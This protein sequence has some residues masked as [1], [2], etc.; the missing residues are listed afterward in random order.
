MRELFIFD[1]LTTAIGEHEPR[2]SVVFCPDP[3]ISHS[4]LKTNL[5]HHFE[6][7]LPPDRLLLVGTDACKDRLTQIANAPETKAALQEMT[8]WIN[9]PTIETLLQ[10]REGRFLQDGKE[11]PRAATQRI[12]KEG[13]LHLFQVRGGLLQSG[14]GFHYRKPSTAHCNKFVRTANV[15]VHGAEISFIGFWLLPQLRN[16][17][18]YLYTD[19]AAI[20]ALAYAMVLLKQQLNASYP[21]P[22]ITSFGSYDGIELCYFEHPSLVL[23]SASTSGNLED[24]LVHKKHL[25]RSEITTIYALGKMHAKANVLCNLGEHG[26][27]PV[28]N[29]DA[30]NCP[31]CRRNVPLIGITGEQFLPETPAVRSELL[32]VNHAPSWL[33]GVVA[34]FLE[35]D[36]IRCNYPP[37]PTD[38]P[39][40]HIYFSVKNIFDGTVLAKKFQNRLDRTILQSTPA[41]LKR[42]I[43]LDDPASKALAERVLKLTKEFRKA[44]DEVELVSARALY[45]EK[46]P[47]P[48]TE[49][50][51]LVVAGAIVTGRSMLAVSQMLRRLQTSTGLVQYLVAL[52]KTASPDHYRNIRSNAQYGETAGANDFRIVSN[53]FL[54][55]DSKIRDTPWEEERKHLRD[56][57]D[58]FHDNP[59]Y[60]AMLKHREQQLDEEE[61]TGGLRQQL[62][63]ETPIE[64]K[65]M[66]LRRGF[67]FWPSDFNTERTTQ[68]EVYF[69]I[70]A[71]LHAA[72]EGHTGAPAWVQHEHE[73][74]I[75]SPYNFSRFNDGVIQASLLRAAYPPELDY[76]VKDEESATMLGVLEHLIANFQYEAG[77]ATV[78]VLFALSTGKLRL[79]GKHTETLLRHLE[80]RQPPP[81]I[82]MFLEYLRAEKVTAHI[83]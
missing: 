2:T 33:K 16:D 59:E 15:L 74:V 13:L 49:G 26:I 64:Q 18:L 62:F 20:N 1:I 42:I 51:V 57:A 60:L 37:Q 12:A 54:P 40:R 58:H 9:P 3:S 24:L 23:I 8:R 28:E 43:H 63:W 66:R 39:I 82:N 83:R 65:P 10:D 76:T 75:L 29:Y 4:V 47:L 48:P 35:L 36:V 67:A 21:T 32:T 79:H 7:R 55:T 72:R 14:P 31:L 22:V 17:I 69:T 25:H 77:E 50:A 38:E 19:T 71:I 52:G 27:T 34:E 30:K 61:Q 6:K 11:Y 53:L 46:N 41:A 78:E 44:N 70:H 80:G 73:R 5:R 56:M 81:V 45:D 68:A